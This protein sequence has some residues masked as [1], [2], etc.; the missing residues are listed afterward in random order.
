MQLNHQTEALGIQVHTNTLLYTRK[1]SYTHIKNQPGWGMDLKVLSLK[2]RYLLQAKIINFVTN[3]HKST[4]WNSSNNIILLLSQLQHPVVRSI[5]HHINYR[6]FFSKY[7]PA[8]P[9]FKKTSPARSP[10]SVS[11]ALVR[12]SSSSGSRENFSSVKVCTGFCLG[13]NIFPGVNKMKV[14]C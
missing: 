11:V 9:S 1:S 8:H 6:S 3:D 14:W 5:H 10:S 13:I 12:A 4:K 7:V 2:I